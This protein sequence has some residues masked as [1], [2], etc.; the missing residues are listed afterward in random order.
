MTQDQ[1]SWNL[2]IMGPLTYNIAAW[3]CAGGLIDSQGSPTDKVMDIHSYIRNHSLHL[4]AVSESE[5]Y[6]ITH[7]TRN[8]KFT[9]KSIED[10]LNIPGY[11]VWFP[12]QWDKHG[13]ARIV[14]WVKG[15]LTVRE[16]INPATDDLP[17]ILV[18]IG[19]QREPKTRVGFIYREYTSYM[20]GLSTGRHRKLGWT[21]PS[22]PWRC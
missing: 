10:A 9:R 1:T 20:T 5:L 14:L 3:N 6:S 15:D 11:D 17:M 19:T 12:Q 7:R 18:E 13:L 22:K 21:A 16:I 8:K 2:I 4:L